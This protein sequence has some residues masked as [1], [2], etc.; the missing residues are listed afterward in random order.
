MS[1][2]SKQQTHVSKAFELADKYKY[3]A[4]SLNKSIAT[5][6]CFLILGDDTSFFFFISLFFVLLLLLLLLLLFYVIINFCK[7]YFILYIYFFHENYLYFFMF[8]HVPEC[9][10]FL[11][12]S[13]PSQLTASTRKKK[14]QSID[15]IRLMEATLTG[16]QPRDKLYS[17]FII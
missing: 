15:L 11:I 5:K 16:R 10:V 12:L 17:V 8:R 2:N 6:C 3:N 9:S 7:N 1:Q 4:K 13:T 14:G